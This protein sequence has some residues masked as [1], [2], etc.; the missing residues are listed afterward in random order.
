MPDEQITT[1]IEIS[2]TGL[3]ELRARMSEWPR[4][5]DGAM[6][7]GM[8]EVLKVLNKNVPPY[9]PELPNQRYRRT[10]RL[11]QS[12]GS[13][14]GGGKSGGVPDVFIVRSMGEGTRPGDVQGEFGSR[15]KYARWVIDERFQA[16][17][18]RGRWWTLRTIAEKATP[19][20]NIIFRGV[21]EGLR[22]WL[23]KK[24]A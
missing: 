23:E 11:G 2:V 5:F 1:D 18:H 6:R 10:E 17:I 20:I 13:G 12:L 16:G 4:K 7:G 22:N 14:F 15:T 3:D 21:V 9:P 24:G 19:Q 8:W